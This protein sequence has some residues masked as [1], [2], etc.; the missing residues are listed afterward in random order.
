MFEGIYQNFNL[1]LAK[2]GNIYNEQSWMGGNNLNFAYFLIKFN[3]F[4]QINTGRTTFL[5]YF[6]KISIKST[7][8][9][10]VTS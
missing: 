5:I 2:C 7:S 6:I 3:D 8:Q 1:F 9:Y 4:D 10:P